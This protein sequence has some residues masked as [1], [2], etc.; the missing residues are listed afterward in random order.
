MEE[1]T[2]FFCI[3]IVTTSGT[4]TTRRYS[5]P[6]SGEGLETMDQIINEVT[7]P[8]AN[9]WKFLTLH[10]PTVG[11]NMS[12]VVSIA[13]DIESPEAEPPQRLTERVRMGF[14]KG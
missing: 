11:Y 9:D 4:P 14:I 13:M 10:Y 8:I 3:T 7:E 6:V 12:Y 5:L 1:S 2:L